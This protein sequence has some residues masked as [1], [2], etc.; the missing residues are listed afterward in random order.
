[1]GNGSGATSRRT[2]TPG[3]KKATPRSRKQTAPAKPVGP[4]PYDADATGR[5]AGHVQIDTVELVG[6]HFERVDD[7]PDAADLPDD[8]APEIGINIAWRLDPD[9]ATLTVLTTFAT[10]FE[11][12]DPEPYELIARFR[13]V[14]TVDEPDAVAEIDAANFAHWNALF[15]AWPYWREYLSSTINRA[16]LPRFVA[17]VMGVPRV[18][19]E[20]P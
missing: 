6:A 2:R 5:V 10:I 8:L 3:A 16:Q 7:G 11:D 20:G 18:G 13:L 19:P 9:A 17:P 1:M 15:N 4:P 14:Y 12:Q